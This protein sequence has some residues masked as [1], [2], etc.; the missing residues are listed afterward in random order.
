MVQIL[1]HHPIPHIL[2]ATP[3]FEVKIA[4]SLQE[5]E[6]ALRL[7]FEVFNLEMQEG[8]QSSYETGFDSDVYDTFCDH[9]IVKER[10]TGAVVGTYRLL[11]QKAVQSIGF[12]SENEFDLSSFRSLRGNLLEAGR[13]CVA[14]PFR[15]LAVINL[16]W[17]GIAR[18]LELHGITH[19]FGCAS[20]KT[21]DPRFM[22]AVHSYCSAHYPAP[23][24]IR[25]APLP[26]CRMDLA[27]HPPTAEEVASVFRR[28]PPLVKGY[29]RLGAYV[30]GE[31]AYDAEFG[32]SDL[33][34]MVATENITSLYKDH[35]LR[36][37]VAA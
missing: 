20:F 16:L 19:L 30:C 18:Y 37:S 23:S 24:S 25:V 15:S 36:S 4:D 29:L 31:P 9:L 22:A 2:C 7:R 28:F 26:H 14:K 13:S 3:T 12:Y 35:Y 10:A 11:R 34:V 1:K 5:V 6:A 21:S 33:L 32:T 17:S 27:S 8:L